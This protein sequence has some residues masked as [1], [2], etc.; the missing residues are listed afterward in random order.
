MSH[1]IPLI[2]DRSNAYIMLTFEDG[3]EFGVFRLANTRLEYKHI[4]KY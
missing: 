2:P 3:L 1:I 4:Q